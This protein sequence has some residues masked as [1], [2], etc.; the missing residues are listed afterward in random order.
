[1]TASVHD[2][3]ERAEQEP[4]VFDAS[5]HEP[6]DALS[7]DGRVSPLRLANLL[8][9]G[10]LASGADGRLWRYDGGRYVPDDEV[11]K[12][13]TFQLMRDR[14]TV[15][16]PPLARDAV[17]LREDFPRLSDTSPD[18]RVVNVR[19]GMVE[20]ATGHCWPH[21]PS[22]RSTVQLPVSYRPDATC[23]RFDAWL[24][25][26]VP[27]AAVPLVW[28]VLAYAIGSD[29]SFQRAA[30][31]L[32]RPGS[33]KSTLLRI[34][35][36][37]LGS[38]H[39]AHVTVPGMVS[40][41]EPASLYGKAA[42]IV[43]DAETAYLADTA[44]F[45][46]IVSGDRITAQHKHQAPFDFTP[47]AFHLFATNALPAS[48]D[49][50]G[51]F[52]RRWVIVPFREDVA[53]DSQFREDRLHA[54]ADGI[55]AKALRVLPSLLRAGRFT[56]PPESMQH[57]ADLAQASDVVRMWLAEDDVIRR[58]DPG[59]AALQAPRTLAYTAYTT[60][61]S[62]SGHRQP[63]TRQAF[64]RRLRELGFTEKR[65]QGLDY[66]RGLDL[67]PNRAQHRWLPAA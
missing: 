25:E 12:R 3:A 49:W 20:V 60:W 24:A 17:T 50:S 30:L 42:N 63:L 23:P 1:M 40:T 44:A 4:E 55:F 39:V 53:T 11:V 56:E 33:G 64:N 45:K 18:P 9:P 31:L 28:E 22:W 2:F 16:L 21:S 67:D 57:Y 37:L 43:A 36:R 62:E 47:W 32:G 26:V 10:D 51:G 61:A 35:E 15:R 27:P 34:V 54:E 46:R 66:W 5:A 8:D 65:V 29:R 52:T 41:F 14:Y 13:R 59:D 38:E 19:N 48:A 7:R 58:A 6:D